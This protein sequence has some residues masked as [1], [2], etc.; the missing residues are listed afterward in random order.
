MW[1]AWVQ[2]LPGIRGFCPPFT[3]I[4]HLE[5]ILL[6]LSSVKHLC[7]LKEYV[8]ISKSK[9]EEVEG[10]CTEFVPEYS[11]YFGVPGQLE[12]LPGKRRG[13]TSSLC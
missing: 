10:T 2:S 5:A 7:V 11:C 12:F 4:F 6:W 3:P 1:A 13:L 9:W 8:F